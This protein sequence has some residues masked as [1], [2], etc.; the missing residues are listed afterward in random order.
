[1]IFQWFYIFIFGRAPAPQNTCLRLRQNGL[2]RGAGSG[3]SLLCARAS[4]IPLHPL[5]RAAYSDLSDFTGLASAAFIL[6]APTVKNAMSAAAAPA[7]TNIHHWIWM[8]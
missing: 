2:G 3:V 1:M 5:T 7:A 8:R 4:R 6:W